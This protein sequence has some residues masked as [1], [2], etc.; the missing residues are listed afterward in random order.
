M[1]AVFDSLDPSPA[2]AAIR[3]AAGAPRPGKARAVQVR[4]AWRD[5]LA[6][7]GP[8]ALVVLA[9]AT[10]FR[11][12]FLGSINSLSGSGLWLVYFILLTYFIGTA[13]VGIATWR[14]TREAAYL[15]R[16]QATGPMGRPALLAG[17]LAGS[18]AKPVYVALQEDEGDP[19]AR[20]SRVE[21]EIA[22]VRDGLGESLTMPN[23][24]NGALVGLGL[25][26]TFVG[27]I[28]TLEDLGALFQGLMSTGNKDANPIDV[29]ADMLKRLQAPMASMATAF[30]TSLYGLGGSLLL[31]LAS[32]LAG[33]VAGRVGDGLTELARVSEIV[34]PRAVPV[35]TT[36]APDHEMLQLELRLRA[37]Q[38]QT[39]LADMRE[40]QQGHARETAALREGI[41]D[42]ARSTQS[43]AQSVQQ[44]MRLDHLRDAS[45]RS[46]GARNASQRHEQELENSLNL[47]R[48]AL[49]AW[50]TKNPAIVAHGSGAPSEGVAN[51]LST[52]NTIAVQQSASLDAIVSSLEQ[53]EQMVSQAMN[54]QLSVT[55]TVDPTR[56]AGPAPKA[57]G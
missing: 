12:V 15:A 31:G 1:A 25:F 7:M 20:Q 50:E 26:G 40:L 6:V 28:G 18:A 4:S 9:C 16:W 46:A 41:A 23:F 57:F 29:F 53:V 39:V 3:P 27:L 22:E 45:R 11:S 56:D 13:L 44:R 14:Y 55:L 36:E 47:A 52:L 54:R 49:Q 38:W 19:F 37:E 32:L 34:Q 33:K 10:V 30:V 17:A 42:V 51:S 21:R 48:K 5:W 43:L 24:V 8:T 35:L 2:V